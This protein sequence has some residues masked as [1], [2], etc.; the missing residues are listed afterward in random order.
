MRDCRE[1]E[2]Y[3]TIEDLRQSCVKGTCTI[4]ASY[5]CCTADVF[6]S[7]SSKGNTQCL[8]PYESIVCLVFIMYTVH[9]VVPDLVM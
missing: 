5:L 1:R 9:T 8:V 3:V 7:S 6:Y 4:L 2:S